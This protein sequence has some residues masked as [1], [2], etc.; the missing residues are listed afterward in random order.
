MISIIVAMDKNNAIGSGSN[1]PWHL[2]ADFAYFKETTFGHPV[3][4]GKKTNDS[5]GRPLPGRTNII[6]STDTTGSMEGCVVRGSLKDA[7]AVAENEVGVTG[8]YFIIGGGSVYSQAIDFADRLYV[9]FV[10]GEFSGDIY[11]PEIDKRKWKEISREKKKSDSKN[12]YDMD[13]VVFERV[14]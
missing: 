2:P 1:I 4:M 6:L 9:T 14:K 5:I 13:F 12:E 3:I 11:F 10:D 8:E 7:M